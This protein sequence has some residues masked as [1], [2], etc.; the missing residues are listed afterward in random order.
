M[1]TVQYTLKGD[2]AD[3]GRH[4]PNTFRYCVECD[5]HILRSRWDGHEDHDR[6]ARERYYQIH[7]HEYGDDPD[8]DREVTKVG[9]WY[10][11]ELSYSVDYRF[12]VPAYSE[13]DAKEVAE[14]LVWNATPADEYL[15]HSTT[16]A[17]WGMED[18]D[19]M[20]DDPQLPDDFDPYG[21]ERLYDAVQRAE[22]DT[23]E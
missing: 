13:S 15:V 16:R 19:I 4:K 8:D 7:G 21:G 22:E 20:S 9:E 2:E 6:Q 17:P 18:S 12:Q 5:E 23:D 1:S 10:E 3:T 14:E 11:V